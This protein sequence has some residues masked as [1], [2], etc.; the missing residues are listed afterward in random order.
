MSN[1][2]VKS[3][4]YDDDD[5]DYD[6]DEPNE[7]QEELSNEDKE[8]LRLGTIEVR[9]VLG[10]VYQ[11]LSTTEI[12][13]AL[14]NYYYDVDKTVARLKGKHQTKQAAKPSPSQSRD[15]FA[16][17]PWGQIPE[18]R[19]ADILI[20]PLHYPRGLL[21]GSSK[22]GKMS[23]L[24]AL[25]AK[26]RQ[27][28]AASTPQPDNVASEPQDDYAA[29]LSRLTLANTTAKARRA[30]EVEADPGLKENSDGTTNVEA[31]N[32]N[33]E[34]VGK[35]EDEPVVARTQPSAFAG[36]FLFNADVSVGRT[37]DPRALK[38]ETQTFDFKDPSPDDVNTSQAKQQQPKT[39]PKAN[40]TNGISGL[41]ISEVPKIKSKNIDVLSEY[42][43]VKHKNA[44]NF[45]VIGHVDA[46]KST[47]MGRLLFDLNAVDQRTMEKYKK[48][49]ENIGKGSFAFAW[50]LD[51]GT[52]ERERG[53]TIDIATN[54]FDTEKTS[55]TILDAPGHQDF[56]PNMIAG[57]SQADFAVLVIDASP[58]NFESGLRGQT[59]EHAVLA[60]AIGVQR[61]IVAVNKL[62]TVQWSQQRFEEIKSQMT[63]FLKA[64]R[65][66]L[67][68]TAFIPCSGLEG[69]NILKP[70]TIDTASWYKGET[71]VQA[72]DAYEP[73][74][75]SLDRP[76]RMTIGDVFR[77][78]IQNPLSISGRIEAGSLQVGEQ[79]LILPS[80]EKATIKA[81]DLDADDSEGIREWAVAG[82][83]VILHLT[84]IDPI[85]LR[86]GDVVCS[87]TNQ[88][89]KNTTKFT[90]QILTFAHLTPMNV[91]I[92]RGRLH[93]PGRIS[94]LVGVLDKKTGEIMK[95]KPKIAKPEEAV[96]VTVELERGM[97]IESGN[98]IV[99]RSQGETVAA[100][101]V[102]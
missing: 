22:E 81:L 68:S 79:I 10:S 39:Q 48:E 54:K 1:R 49:A 57:A 47:L 35:V 50:V 70:V 36:T 75:H 24:A 82:Q 86:S 2:R 62:D 31:S 96:R 18:H 84:D 11:P 58:G 101:L 78:G 32:K 37:L 45:V 55:F 12:E 9:R 51:Q 74:T 69:Q 88:P 17:C 19:R 95:K 73:I 71:L 61:L 52:E 34:P 6:Y 100:G 14:W 83:N 102:E 42:N 67:E 29:S 65:F 41:S 72:L 43:K 33:E 28:E 77:G 21:G 27:K 92:H 20:E 40:V 4:D 30:K 13:D 56:V 46:G 38:E 98:R 59:R 8:Q 97:P 60:K 44:A 23:K 93:V 85:H 26:R 53:V 64:T 63:T 15:I 66:N 91:D 87:P 25:A 3:L 7:D 89:L 80:G 16:D 76:L 94:Q 5:L 90:A 99:L